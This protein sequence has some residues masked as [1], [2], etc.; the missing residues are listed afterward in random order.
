MFVSLRL[1]VLFRVLAAVGFAGA[2]LALLISAGRTSD[3]AP[4]VPSRTPRIGVEVTSEPQDVRYR[5]AG[6]GGAGLIVRTC[7]RVTCAKVGRLDEGS[8]QRV[9]CWR[10][11]SEVSGDQRWLRVTVDGKDGFAS[12][13]YLRTDGGAGAPECGGA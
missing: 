7:P 6:T 1:G 12:A 2:V 13:H 9:T 3:G 5:V 10:S 8:A 11:G 4:G